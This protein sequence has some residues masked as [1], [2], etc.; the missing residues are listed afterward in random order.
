MADT[1]HF[2]GSRAQAVQIARDLAAILTGK[3]ADTL[4]LA[5]GVFLAVGFAALSDIK[6][7]FVRKA[8]GQRGEDGVQWAPLSREYLAYQR[9]FG[10]GEKGRL[11]AAAGVGKSQRFGVGGNKGLLTKAQQKRWNQIFA[12]RLARFLLSMGDAEAKVRAA[13]IAWATI[14]REGARTTLEVFGSRKVQIQ[15]DTGVLLNSLSPG[16]LSGGAQSVVYT[17]PGDEGGEQQIMETIANGVIVGTNVPYAEHC[18]K[19]RP[20]L[21]T[22]DAPQAWKERWSEAAA[23]ALQAAA[24]L[25]YEQGS[26]A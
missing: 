23:D 21:P 2:R 22:G 10:P 19:Q 4:G 25:A 1:V 8:D 11:K 7:D 18:Q 12:S 14:K 15:R 13:Q 5:K 6:D 24:R 16:E 17:K 9:R 3:R 20:F 26:A